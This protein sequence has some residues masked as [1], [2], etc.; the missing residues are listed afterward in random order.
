M[1]IWFRDCVEE[2]LLFS[3]GKK[4]FKIR[5]KKLGLLFGNLNSIWHVSLSETHFQKMMEVSNV[6]SNI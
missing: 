3:T 1:T 6:F 4:N 2:G 5:V